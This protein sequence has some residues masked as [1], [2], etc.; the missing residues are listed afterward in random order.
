MSIINTL[1]FQDLQRLRKFVQMEHK[2][3]F[4][5]ELPQTQVDQFI[6]SYWGEYMENELEKAVNLGTLH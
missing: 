2:R 3:T 5:V 1:S 4:G 6:E